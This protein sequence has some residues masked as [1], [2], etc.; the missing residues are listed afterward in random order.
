MQGKS[1]PPSGS[2]EHRR[3]TSLDGE[4]GGL[5]SVP[6]RGLGVCVTAGKALAVLSPTFHLCIAKGLHWVPWNIPAAPTN[7][8]GVRDDHVA[9]RR[10]HHPSP[11]PA[12]SFRGDWKSNVQHQGIPAKAGGALKPST[13]RGEEGSPT[14][15]GCWTRQWGPCLP[16]GAEA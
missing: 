15:P 7:C 9:L 6:E 5:D 10:P 8:P 1:R 12:P 16:A 2:N 13:R 14:P 4:L 11:P 3:H